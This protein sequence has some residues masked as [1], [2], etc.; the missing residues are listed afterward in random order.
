MADIL[1]IVGLATT[2]TTNLIAVAK[3]KEARRERSR[4]F[5]RTLVRQLSNEGYN[6]VVVA[7]PWRAWGYEASSD[8]AFEGKHYTLFA[9]PKDRVMI[10][11]NRGD[12]GFENWALC[13]S[14]W[15][16]WGK[17]VKFHP[18]WNSATMGTPYEI[19]HPNDFPGW[20]E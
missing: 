6:A 16:R 10:V 12:G 11:E 20:P 4:Q 9:A 1:S 7:G 3:K 13:G 8:H 5:T 14:N 15:V 19:R 17:I 18:S 2:I